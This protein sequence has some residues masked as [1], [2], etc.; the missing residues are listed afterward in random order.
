MC[1]FNHSNHS[2]GR[3]SSKKSQ[4]VPIYRA[5]N[6]SGGACVRACERAF[7]SQICRVA[8]GGLSLG[9]GWAI[10]WSATFQRENEIAFNHITHWMGVLDDSGATYTLGPHMNSTLH[11]NY[12]AHAGEVG[13]VSGGPTGPSGSGIEPGNSHHGGAVS[14]AASCCSIVAS[15]L[16]YGTI[17]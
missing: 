7:R 16:V 15:L 10:P 11:H 1:L 13:M 3:L 9:W 5:R 8:Y 2:A 14:A 17:T 12:A 4:C 6:D